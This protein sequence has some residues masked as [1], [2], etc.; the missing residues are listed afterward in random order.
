VDHLERD[1]HC[2]PALRVGQ[3]AVRLVR[4]CARAKGDPRVPSLNSTEPVIA[5]QRLGLKPH[6]FENSPRLWMA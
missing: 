2:L 6:P 3:K 4:L 5:L 1:A